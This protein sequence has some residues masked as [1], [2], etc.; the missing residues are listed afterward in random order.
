MLRRVTVRTSAT[1]AAGGG[2]SRAGGPHPGGCTPS[3]VAGCEHLTRRLA[4][5]ESCPVPVP[6]SRSRRVVR[7]VVRRGPDRRRYQGG[8]DPALL[9]AG[10]PLRRAPYIDR[11]HQSPD[12]MLIFGERHLRSV[13]ARY[14]VHYNR[15]RPHRAL[16][17]RPPRPQAPVPKPVHGKSRR[18]PILGGLINR[19]EAAPWK[20][21]VKSP[22]DPAGSI[23]A[24]RHQRAAVPTHPGHQNARDRL[25]PRRLWAHPAATLRPVHAR[26]RRPLPTRTGK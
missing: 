14:A 7:G 4:P 26:G 1:S 12:R 18:R 19:Y 8:Q 6:P 2:N 23:A 3:R 20:L 22:P 17:L 5:P 10:E 11:P 9:S 24:H 13:L 16:Q 25:L 21:L 15:R